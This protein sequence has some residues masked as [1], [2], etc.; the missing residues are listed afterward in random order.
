MNPVHVVGASLWTPGVG[1]V[2]SWLAGE[3]D[4]SIV[5]PMCAVLPSRQ[6]RATSLTTRMGIEVLS[7]AI[8][9][10]GVDGATTKLV[11]G[12]AYGEFQTAVSQLEMMESDDGRLSPARF[13]NSVHNTVTG[14]LSIAL[15]NRGFCTAIAAGAQTFAMCLLD[16]WTVLETQGGTAAVAVADEWPGAPFDEVSFPPLG[17]GLCL[18]MDPLFRGKSLATL[19]T[20]RRISGGERGVQ[21]VDQVFGK[22]SASAALSLLRAIFEGRSGTVIVDQGDSEPWCCD[23]DVAAQSAA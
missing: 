6:R 21:A 2:T 7:Q 19:S 22:N 20:L 11:F 12:S 15:E 1:D 14:L 3:Q 5:K 4:D 17:V 18:T 9:S 13:K 23:V 16:G 10:A 8:S